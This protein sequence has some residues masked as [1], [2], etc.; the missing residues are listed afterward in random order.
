M[1]NVC[2]YQIYAR[3]ECVSVSVLY[4]SSLIERE[5]VASNTLMRNAWVDWFETGTHPIRVE[6]DKSTRQM[7][8]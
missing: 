8:L 1:Q 5:R 6:L 3:M 2:V 7:W 4:L